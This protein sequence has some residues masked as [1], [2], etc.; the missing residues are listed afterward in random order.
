MYLDRNCRSLCACHLSYLGR[1][2]F[3]RHC[4]GASLVRRRTNR[5]LR[6]KRS[7]DLEVQ[8]KIRTNLRRC[9]R[10]SVVEL[11]EFLNLLSLR[12]CSLLRRDAPLG[13]PLQLGLEKQTEMIFIWY[14]IHHSWYIRIICL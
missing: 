3:Q 12:V 14:F 2:F 9:C 6:P 4:R 8:R 1:E 13:D 11:H 5:L 10:S 7:E